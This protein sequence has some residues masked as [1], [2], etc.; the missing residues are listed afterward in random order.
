VRPE[1]LI[2]KSLQ[3]EDYRRLLAEAIVKVSG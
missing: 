3:D 2:R 1:E